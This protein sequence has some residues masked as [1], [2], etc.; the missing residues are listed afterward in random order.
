MSKRKFDLS[1]TSNT[2]A[3]IVVRGDVQDNYV[4]NFGNVM[5]YDK[6]AVMSAEELS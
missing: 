3:L 4:R 5:R 2:P 1:N 6:V